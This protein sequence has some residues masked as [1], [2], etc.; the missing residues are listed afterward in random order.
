MW[1]FD[2]FTLSLLLAGLM[3][4]LWISEW[5]PVYLTALFPLLFAVPMGLLTPKD[6][7]Q[8]YGD[9]NIFL[10]F[11]GFVLAL[12][13]EKWG[14]H[15]QIARRIIAVVGDKKSN[16]LLGFILSTGM[17][18]M[19]ISNTATALMMLPMAIAVIEAMPP[20]HRHSR[21]SVFLMLSIAYASNIGGVGTLI[22]SPPNTQMASILS[23]SFQVEISFF[24]W[25]KIGMPLA[26]L[27]LL[28]MF[29][30]FN[31]LL[32]AERKD[33]HDLH[34]H[35]LPWT[36]AQKRV[37]WI[38]SMVAFLWIFREVFV[39]WGINY[40][41]ENA[42]IL[43]A[44]A[45]F[46]MPSGDGQKEKILR[47]SDT[48]KLPW[49]ILLLFGGGLALAAVLEKNGVLQFLA[50]SFESFD[51]IG[52]TAAVLMLTTLAIFISEVLSNLAMVTLFV[53]VVG[54][55]ATQTGLPLVPMAMALTLGA[56]LAF[57]MPVGTPPNA[58][59]F[60][61]GYLR[62]KDMMRYGFILNLISLALISLF[63]ILFL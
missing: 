17:I 50:Q 26:I 8:C 45:M 60:G 11:G 37:L 44:L 12:G 49:G 25:M 42:A 30:I 3:V 16:I 54:I 51:G 46:L 47:W 32:G 34:F 38:F 57:M 15:E 40:R 1:V 48:E 52:L 58:I 31:M 2:G 20:S 56:S 62:I 27:L 14:V 7:A 61:S 41:D 23:E 55:F 9:A 18:S 24:D 5:I 6:L 36:K 59:V 10:F 29:L 21:F 43:G 22:G 19:W 53:P 63:V 35:T 13:L 33:V 39:G 28:L 4:V